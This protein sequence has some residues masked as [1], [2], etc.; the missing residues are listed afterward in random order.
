[1]PALRA[2]L[3]AAIDSARDDILYSHSAGTPLSGGQYPAFPRPGQK[4]R[5]RIGPAVGSDG[6]IYKDGE[7]TFKMPAANPAKNYTANLDQGG[8]R[9]SG[10]A[11]AVDHRTHHWR[12]CH[13]K[14]ILGFTLNAAGIR[15]EIANGQFTVIGRTKL[16]GQDAIEL[17]INVPPNNEA[18]P[19][20]TAD[21]LLVNATTYLPMREYVRMSNGQHSVSDYVFL[22]ATPKRLANLRPAIPAG[23]TRVGCSHATGQKPRTRHFPPP[24]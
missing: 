3:L 8:L 18:P 4:V 6:K 22:R 21:R 15:S 2:H 24:Q 14:F 9:L 11:I 20:V 7:F 17:R 5:V 13:A 12:D 1:M 16:H 19:H 10:K 23:Y